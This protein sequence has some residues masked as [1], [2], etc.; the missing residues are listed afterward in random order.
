MNKIPEPYF[1]SPHA[2]KR[3]IRRV[4][5]CRESEAIEQIQIDLQNAKIVERFLD[6]RV[7]DCGLYYAL[8]GPPSVPR[9]QE[10]P[11]VITIVDTSMYHPV[12]KPIYKKPNPWRE[13]K[14]DLWQP[15]EKHYLRCHWGYI[16]SKILARHLGRTQKA[17]QQQ[18]YIIRLTRRSY[19]S[20]H[21]AEV[22]TL[23][24][25]YSSNTI[26]LVANL[27]GRTISSVKAKAHSLRLGNR[28]YPVAWNASCPV[29]E[30][31]CKKIDTFV[32]EGKITPSKEFLQL[33]ATKGYT[34]ILSGPNST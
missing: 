32:T 16:P 22:K 2:V 4:N 31:Y 24:W 17:V 11:S 20:W 25:F 18:A 12:D 6:K 19:R 8:V 30:S 27:L 9:E 15:A 23:K 10:W 7:Y 21:R 26:C 3:Y 13:S 33:L 28:E 1:V 29:F 14:K 5:P 34:S